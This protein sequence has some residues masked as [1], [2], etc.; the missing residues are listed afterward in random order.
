MTFKQTWEP[1]STADVEEVIYDKVG[2]TPQMA[3]CHVKFMM[4]DVFY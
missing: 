1:L 3:S 2:R 4:E